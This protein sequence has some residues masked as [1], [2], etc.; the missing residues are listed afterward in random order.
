MPRL[1]LVA[2]ATCIFAYGAFGEPSSSE[3]SCLLQ[4]KSQGQRANS[5]DARG[6]GKVTTCPGKGISKCLKKDAVCSVGS[7]L[8]TF[9]K[10]C[11]K[12]KKGPCCKHSGSWHCFC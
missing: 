3:G 1:M 2:V 8:V 9:K 6:I 7:Y 4:T 5:T 12:C 11:S 10:K